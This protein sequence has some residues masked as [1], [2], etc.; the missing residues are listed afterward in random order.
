MPPLS[1]IRQDVIMEAARKVALAHEARMSGSPEDGHA[2]VA[3]VL[4][5]AQALSEAFDTEAEEY[6]AND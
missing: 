2:D 5:A 6:E 4:V 1:R 3:D